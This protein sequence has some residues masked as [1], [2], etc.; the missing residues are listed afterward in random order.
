MES[1]LREQAHRSRTLKEIQNERRKQ[2][3]QS[4]QEENSRLKRLVVK[5]SETIMRNVAR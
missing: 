1:E 4:L 2:A 3:F 5:L